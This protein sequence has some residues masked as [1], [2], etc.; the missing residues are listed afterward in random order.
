MRHC[1]DVFSSGAP[2]WKEPRPPWLPAVHAWAGGPR[3]TWRRAT[4]AP[5]P[6]LAQ[7]L[8]WLRLCWVLQPACEPLLPLP[9]YRPTSEIFVMGSQETSDAML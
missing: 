7:G 1:R 3:Q 6:R 4:I 2:T 9:M 8:S 5:V